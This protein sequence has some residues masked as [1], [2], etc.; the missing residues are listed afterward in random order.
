[1]RDDTKKPLVG[2]I[3]ED[4]E[5]FAR[6]LEIKLR[7]WR[8]DIELRIANCIAQ[9]LEYLEDKNNSFSFVILDQHLPD[10][11]GSVLFNH[12]A[13]D[14][15]TVL[16]VSADSAPDLPGKAVIAG[17]QHFLQKSQA[18]EA[19]FIPLLEALLERKALEKQLLANK[20]HD[21]ELRTIKILLATLRHEINN[22]LGAVLGGTY[23]LKQKGD[24]LDD[25]IEA[26]RLIEASS[27]RIK[28]VIDKLCETARLEEVIKGQEPVFQVPGDKPWGVR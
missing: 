16:A 24:L 19:L 4:D 10:G 21:S 26:L 23:L 15:T 13:L 5:T 22:P 1:M 11:L 12:P 28:H 6:I 9:A 14:G 25:Q 18:T 27:H 20:L 7:G 3:V 2:L 17:A 8:R